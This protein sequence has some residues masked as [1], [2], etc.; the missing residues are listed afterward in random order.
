MLTIMRMLKRHIKTKI[1][2]WKGYDDLNN[3]YTDIVG[4][5]W[6]TGNRSFTLTVTYKTKKIYG[7]TI[8][9]RINYNDESYIITEYTLP[10]VLYINKDVNDNTCKDDIPP[11]SYL[12]PFYINK[13]MIMS[14]NYDVGGGSLTYNTTKKIHIT[15]GP[16]SSPT[17]L[18]YVD[19]DE[20]INTKIID[21]KDMNVN[22][23]DF[24]D[25]VIFI[26]SRESHIVNNY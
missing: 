26:F 8:M 5:H 13:D 23:I 17:D 22:A 7:K 3:L 11:T 4:N 12:L 15:I 2:V 9:Y 16:I 1:D 19:K 18:I 25:I 21:K 20:Q 14:N 6:S 24:N 10:N